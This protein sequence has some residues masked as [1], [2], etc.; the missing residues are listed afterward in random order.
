MAD[1]VTY[2][3]ARAAETGDTEDLSK[4]ELQRRMEEARE[5]ISQTVAEI[6]D[7]VVN[8]YQSVRDTVTET[9]DWREQYRKRPLA[10]SIGAMGAGFI[11]GYSLAGVF[12]G[13][14]YDDDED[15]LSPEDSRVFQLPPSSLESSA[16]YSAPRA[17]AAQAITGGAYGSSAYAGSAGGEADSNAERSQA[18]RGADYSYSGGG[19]GGGATQEEEEPQG[20]GLIERFKETKAYDR[21]QEEVSTLGDRFIEELSRTAQAVVLPALFSKVKDLF[22][23]DLSGKG[24]QSSGGTSSSGGRTS[25]PASAGSGTA[26]GGSSSSSSSYATTDNRPYGGGQGGQ[27]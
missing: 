15:T 12:K 2:G 10:W 27:A 17:Y 22:G 18:S 21:L 11:V 13:D 25:N 1:E 19:S 4:A 6:K 9:L 5:S 7:T 8:Q 26:G 24:S 14:D 20:P 16:S 23:V 3:T